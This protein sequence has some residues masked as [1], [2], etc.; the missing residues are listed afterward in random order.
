MLTDLLTQPEGKMLEFKENASSPLR[1]IKTVLAFANTAG[2]KVVIGIKDKDHSVIG[3]ENIIVEEQRLTS[4]IVDSIEPMLIPDIDIVSHEDKELIVINVPYL[5]GPYYLKSSGL[6]KGVF[7]RLGS[8]NRMA[9]PETISS[10]QRLAKNISFDEMPCIN[11]NPEELDDNYIRKILGTVYKN[12]DKKH[13]RSLGILAQHNNKSFASYGGILLF[14]HDK[15]R[16]LPDSLIRCVCFAG[17]GRSEI[18]DQKDIKVP[19]I[20]AVDEVLAF[21]NRHINVSARFTG[22]SRRIDIPQFPP[23]AVREAVVNTIVHA[24][25]TMIGGAIQIAVFAD[26]IEITNPGGLAFGQ[27]MENALS[28][29]SRMRNR[30]IGRI[31]REIKI[32]EQL[33]TGLLRIVEAYKDYP[34]SQPLIEE[35]DHHFRVTLFESTPAIGEMKIWESTLFKLLADGRQ[36]STKQI[37]EFWGV[38]DRTARSRLKAMLERRII[39]RHAETINDPNTSYSKV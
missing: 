27:S 26:R 23:E 37:A 7:I 22:V 39:K 14:G 2:G 31:F 11:A 3:V 34:Q 15:L 17:T 25:Y 10:L 24:D 5:I 1:I 8:T 38:T 20:D 9:A 28:G 4:L 32:I 35:I 16:W 6:R 12:L 30:L 21:I 13:Y 19:L 33:G 18:I 36:L 29:V